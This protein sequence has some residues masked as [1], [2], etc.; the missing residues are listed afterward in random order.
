MV[1]NMNKQYHNKHSPCSVCN[2]HSTMPRHQGIRCYGYT[3][4]GE[5]GDMIAMCTRENYA[6]LLQAGET[7]AFAHRLSAKCKCGNPHGTYIEPT[8]KTPTIT[9]E[10]KNE[11]AMEIWRDSISI[12]GTH[13]HGYLRARGITMNLSDTFR[14]HSCLHD[15][16]SNAGWPTLV[17]GVRVWPL[18]Q[19]VAI[20]RTYLDH[21]QHGVPCKAP[22]A[23]PK[24]RLGIAK[25]GAVRIGAD[26]HNFLIL[27]EGIEDA[28]SIHQDLESPVWAVMG[29][30]F[31]SVI[32]PSSVRN[33]CLASDSD[34]DGLEA[35]SRAARY[36]TEQG[37]KVTIS[38]PLNGAKDF[39][40]MLLLQG[41]KL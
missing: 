26:P 21:D 5:N 4:T 11:M 40:E 41:A 20:H 13:A 6:G 31:A 25:G 23:Q 32:I 1:R 9:D 33:I 15:F 37:L 36:L 10:Q 24:K 14:Y 28:L 22:I 2:G 35:S 17:S 16:G 19:V 12:E 38:T 27:T 7:G 34:P 29:T 18:N 39:N 30:H 8:I 3:F